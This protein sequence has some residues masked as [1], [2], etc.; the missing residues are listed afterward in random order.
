MIL[1]SKGCKF[2]ARNC[3]F[4]CESFLLQFI[5]LATVLKVKMNCANS[6]GNSQADLFLVEIGIDLRGRAIAHQ[7]ANPCFNFYYT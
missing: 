1:L 7:F 5:Y 2:T 6:I 3:L 4:A